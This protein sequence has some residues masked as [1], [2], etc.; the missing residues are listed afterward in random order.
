VPRLIY[1][2]VICNYIV[3]NALH[4]LC[5]LYHYDCFHICK[6]LMECENKY[7]NI[8][9]WLAAWN[10]ISNVQYISVSYT[11]LRCPSKSDVNIHDMVSLRGLLL[12]AQPLSSM[13]I[14]AITPNLTTR[15]LHTQWYVW[16]WELAMYTSLEIN[17]VRKQC[18]CIIVHYDIT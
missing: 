8:D 4:T 1:L 16:S 13:R 5:N 3:T 12:A 18:V 10:T 9:R 2:Y 14:T 7:A 11:V 15:T 17:N 6:D